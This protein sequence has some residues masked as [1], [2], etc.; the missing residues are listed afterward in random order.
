M[1]DEIKDVQTPDTQETQEVKLSEVEQKASAEGWVP[2]DQWDGDPDK[3]RPAKEFLDRG[4]LFKKIE[5]QTST[6]KDLRKAI[7]DLAK[8]NEN[9]QKVEFER[10]LATLKSQ[11]KE[12]IREGD[13]DAVVDIDERMDIIRE[14]QKSGPVIDVP[15]VPVFNPVFEQW[16]EKNSWYQSNRAMTVFADDLARELADRKVSPTDMLARIRQEVEKEFPERFKNPRR[17]AP[18]AVEGS[19]NKGGRKDDVIQLSEQERRVAE[20]IV[21]V[22]PG[23]TMKKYLEQYAAYN[24]KG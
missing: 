16:K 5:G 4:E 14:A 2:Q 12:A 7:A 3:W 10:A 15:E 21:A 6:I 22:T 18:G 11:K 17:D 1:A 24:K 13:G 9:I 8:H 19:S 23:M 20:R